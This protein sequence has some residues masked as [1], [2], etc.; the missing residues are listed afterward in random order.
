MRNIRES[1]TL[2]AVQQ[3]AYDLLQADARFVYTLCHIAANAKNVKSNY[4]LMCQPYIGIFTDGAEQWCKKVGVDAPQFTTEEKKYYSQLRLSH[5][6]FELPYTDYYSALISKLDES[7]KYFYS[8][9]S[10]LE[11]IIGY[12][13]I[14]TDFCYGEFCGNTA[15]CALYTPVSTLGNKNIGPWIKEMS[16]ISGKLAASLGC[17]NFPPYAY[18]NHIRATYK[19][20][21]FFE[22]CPVSDKSEFGFLLFSVL[23]SINFVTVFIE[24]FFVDEIPQKFK[25]A[26]LQYYYLCGFVEE[27]NNANG[28]HFSINDSLKNQNFR[29]CLSHYGLGQFMSEADLKPND[30]LRGLTDKA[31]GLDYS[32]AKKMLYQNLNDFAQQIKERIGC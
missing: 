19:D 3:A 12:Y 22:N 26:Y 14:G 13:N 30:A 28:T 2:N 20:Y 10:N 23:C 21:H 25:F 8:I 27:I 4:I 6:L 29:N 31:F 1:I 32:S 17:T 7:D 9:R 11:K 24:K 16:V 18:S 15:L 5:K